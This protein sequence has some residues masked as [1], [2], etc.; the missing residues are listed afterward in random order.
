MSETKQFLEA[1]F[2]YKPDDSYILIWTL[3]DKKS[4]WFRDINRINEMIKSGLLAKNEV[5]L[6][7]GL[8]SEETYK[9]FKTPDYQRCLANEVQGIVGLW[10]DID[11]QDPAH[12]K[13]NLPPDKKS[14]I[15]LLN[16]MPLKPTIIVDS[17]HGLH[18][19]WLFKEPWI[20]EDNEERKDGSR[21]E[22]G[23]L[24]LLKEKAGKHNWD[25]DSTI[26]LSRVLRLPG[27]MNN[28]GKPVPVKIA[29]HN[30][31]L[32]YNPT[33]FDEYIPQNIEEKINTEIVV[34]D[35]TLN[36]NAQPPF[37]KFAALLHVDEKIKQSWEHKRK[38]MQ[39]QSASSY[40]LSLA[41]Y[42]AQAGWTD[43][44]IA[45]L[46]IAHRRK[47]G[48][49]PKLRLDYYQRTISK[50]REAADDVIVEEDIE[51]LLDKI[52]E[53]DPELLRKKFLK[54]ISD[55]FGVK[56][57]KIIKYVSDPPQYRLETEKGSIMLGGASNILTQRTFRSNVFAATNI[58]IPKMK[59]D[60]WDGICQLIGHAC[61]EETIGDEATN[62]GTA[63]SW[64]SGYLAERSILKDDP[65]SAAVQQLPYSVDG[66]IYIFGSDF[67]KWLRVSQMEKISSKQMGQI[68]R[69]FGCTPEKVNV[70]IEGNPTTRSVWKIPPSEFKN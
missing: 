3:P 31:F 13:K 20:F 45:D 68:L 1:L 46:M 47:H 60:K 12:K 67:R 32:R 65:D 50:A 48:E 61:I 29:V 64:L 33:D 37:E 40:D 15:S 56:V 26:D 38:D 10:A 19:W 62:E 21:I 59:G 16:E 39:D 54:K 43:Q 49:D 17:G 53:E 36:A 70:N 35:L 30:D 58:V 14:A 6:G 27:T 63:R 22:T 7:V 34:G 28:K 42:A 23:W 69:V 41:T 4:Y 18:A 5:Y 2:E 44:E 9:S 8:T 24:Y 66:I 25:V 52:N 11:I 57:T 55:E 51:E